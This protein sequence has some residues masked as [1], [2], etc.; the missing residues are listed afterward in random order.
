[1]NSQR[2][3]F[4]TM[5]STC[6]HVLAMTGVALAAT[7]AQ[8]MSFAQAWDA[9]RQHD[10]QYQ[11]ATHELA[12]AQQLVPIARAALL[13]QVALNASTNEVTG[14]REF[15]NSLNQQVRTRLDYSA[16]QT[17]LSLRL[18]IFNREAHSRLGQAQAQ[19]EVAESLFR[20][21]GLDLVDR[22]AV[23]YM[24]VLL[25]QD[26]RRLTELQLQAQ[27]VQLKQLQQRLQRGEGTRVETA[28][29]QAALDVLRVRRTESD[30]QLELARR[31]LRRITGLPTPELRSLAG[32]YQ[33]A[34]MPAESLTEWLEIAVRQSPSLQAR[35]QALVA[36]KMNVQRNFAG[37]FPRL[38]LVASAS[39]NQNETTS[40]LNQ[41]TSLRSLGLQ[42]SVPI[43]S[44][45]GV[46]ASV[47]QALSDQSRAEEEIRIERETLEIEVQ[48]YYQATQ[49]GQARIEAMRTSV[50]AAELALL[51]T[52]R[53][54][55]AGLSTG[56]DVAEAQAR[57][58]GTRRELA[59]MR[60][61]YLLARTRLMVQAGMPMAE[62]AADVDRA[63]VADTTPAMPA[64]A[65]TPARP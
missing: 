16:P 41:T 59:Q 54:L 57:L 9:S 21:K 44:G 39:H 6:L 60:L 32:D 11:S 33:P 53:A 3:K 48:R 36:A 25:A 2:K 56:N 14:S 34:P 1:M 38:D 45:G 35:Q 63:L 58:F 65:Q 47:K 40:S 42:L 15:P 30:D 19:T 20:A 61:D 10:A 28:Q 55:E 26:S 18:P 13:P 64:P 5:T 50:A 4:A 49:T 62:V 51:G 52:Q 12:S 27:A 17:S 31:Q 46:D 37:H 24:Q 23:A 43:F 29:S 22:L 8:A 7:T